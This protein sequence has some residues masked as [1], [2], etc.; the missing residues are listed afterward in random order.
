MAWRATLLED[1]LDPWLAL[2]PDAARRRL[3]LEFLVELCESGGRVDG[4]VEVPGTRL[5]A[6]ATIVAGT[7]VVLVWV[8]ADAYEELAIRYL[9]DVT[10]DQYFGG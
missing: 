2:E 9:Y 3:V 6:Y 4:A 8:I 7:G 5:P 10:R 1:S